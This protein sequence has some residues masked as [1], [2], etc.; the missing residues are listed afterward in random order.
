[1]ATFTS[2]QEQFE[3]C[4]NQYKTNNEKR[5]ADVLAKLKRMDIIFKDQ[6][7]LKDF[8]DVKAS[9]EEGIKF[10][11]KDRDMEAKVAEIQGLKERQEE[12]I[13]SLL[14]R[15]DTVLDEY[16][17]KI[18]EIESFKEVAKKTS[19][20]Y[21]ELLE[22]SNKLSE[23]FAGLVKE[24][25]ELNEKHEKKYQEMDQK[26][27]KKYQEIDQKYEKKFRDMDEKYEKA[28]DGLTKE[29][30][31]LQKKMKNQSEKKQFYF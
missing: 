28:I 21:E 17:V 27:E 26:H 23:D 13:K 11:K 3:L 30:K 5:F 19:E 10:L 25:R 12:E 2:F 14:N 4:L 15:I 31:N 6:A 22:K 9:I 8:T 16:G 29:L 20:A 24:N 1:L 7:G 18:L